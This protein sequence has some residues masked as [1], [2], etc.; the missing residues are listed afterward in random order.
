M[1]LGSLAIGLAMQPFRQLVWTDGVGTIAYAGAAVGVIALLLPRRD[2]SS[3]SG[4]AAALVP[5]A[6]GT[7]L[8]CAVEI[9]QLTGIPA[10]LADRFPPIALLLGRSFDPLDL[11]LLVLGGA[12]ATL[13]LSA[14]ARG[15]PGP[16]SEP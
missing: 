3:R 14:S 4:R 11:G 8:A 13:A 1:L 6:I 7:G 5:G 15:G 9:F 10:A 12:L 2:P 16:S